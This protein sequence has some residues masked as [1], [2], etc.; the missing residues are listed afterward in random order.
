MCRL[1][2]PTQLDLQEGQLGCVAEK[3]WRD[4]GYQVVEHVPACMHTCT[5]N[6]WSCLCR[7]FVVKQGAHGSTH[8]RIPACAAQSVKHNPHSRAQQLIPLGFGSEE[9]I[10]CCIA[11]DGWERAVGHANTDYH[12]H[13]HERLRVSKQLRAQLGDDVVLHITANVNTYVLSASSSPACERL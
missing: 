12:S 9:L 13:V 2:L 1:L 10:L 7:V 8:A 5:P 11:L 4:A 3:V 6:R